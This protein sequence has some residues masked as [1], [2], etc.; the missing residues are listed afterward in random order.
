MPDFSVLIT[1]DGTAFSEESLSLLPFLKSVG[2]TRVRLV[3]VWEDVEGGA[4]QDE[5][6]R[7]ASETGRAYLNAYLQSKATALERAGLVLEPV[8]CF[9]NAAEEVLR[10]AEESQ[11]NL[12]VIATHGRSGI[13][14][15]RLGSVADKV[16]RAASC[17]T[18]VIGPNVKVDLANYAIKRVMVPLDGSALAEEGLAVAAALAK[19]ANATVELIG[20]AHLPNTW[21]AEPLYSGLNVADVLDA[22]TEASEAYLKKTDLPGL[23]VERTVLSTMLTGEVA[24]ALLS[25]LRDK[26]AELIVLTSHGRHGVSRWALGSVTDELLRGPAPVLVLR[27]GERELTALIGSA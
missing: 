15:W 9:G 6:F 26:P 16:I 5:R 1:L 24:G 14:R 11:S 18:L 2:V 17:P 4:A 20:V 13:E 21:T 27:P 25:H 19:R 22:L 23:T 10:L 7:Q 12:I 3:S 8:V